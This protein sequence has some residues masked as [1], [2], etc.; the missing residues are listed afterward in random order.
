MSILPI[1][2]SFIPFLGIQFRHSPPWPHSL[3]W[4]RCIPFFGIPILASRCDDLLVATFLLRLL[5]FLIALF[6]HSVYGSRESIFG[7]DCIHFPLRCVDIVPDP[8]YSES[9]P[10]MIIGSRWKGPQSPQSTYSCTFLGYDCCLFPYVLLGFLPMSMIGRLAYFTPSAFCLVSL[11]A[12]FH[13]C[14]ICFSARRSSWRSR[15]SFRRSI[16]F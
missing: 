5:S 16:S 3:S 4:M 13:S 14:A 10:C 9:W 11:S 12:R 1:V 7:L 2:S 15:F 8:G 6:L